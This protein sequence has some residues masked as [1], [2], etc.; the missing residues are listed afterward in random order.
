MNVHKENLYGLAQMLHK[1]VYEVE[2]MPASE[3]F[4]WISY[5]RKRTEEQERAARAASG[6][7]LAM[8]PKEMVSGLTR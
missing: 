6:D 4:G 8:S 3:Y 2:R 5:M 7:L 1:C